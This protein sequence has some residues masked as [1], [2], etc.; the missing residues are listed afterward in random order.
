MV[1]K[2]NL[3][4]DEEEEEDENDDDAEDEEGDDGGDILLFSS[5]TK[6]SS[7]E[8]PSKTLACD[9]VTPVPA[10]IFDIP[11]EHEDAIYGDFC[12]KKNCS[13]AK[14]TE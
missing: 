3:S 7:I 4:N 13:S 1:G 14:R 9:R 12:L 5:T 11:P 6:L 8:P 10:G 2:A